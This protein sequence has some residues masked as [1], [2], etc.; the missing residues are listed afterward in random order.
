MKKMNFRFHHFK[1]NYVWQAFIYKEKSLVQA[2]FFMKANV[3][4]KGDTFLEVIKLPLST[5]Y[6]VHFQCSEEKILPFLRM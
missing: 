3:V 5:Y 2:F 6:V 1:K 4:K